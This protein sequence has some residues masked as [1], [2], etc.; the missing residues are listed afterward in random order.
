MVFLGLSG[1]HHTSHHTPVEC[2]SCWTYWCSVVK[3]VSHDVLVNTDHDSWWGCSYS[4][5]IGQVGHDRIEIVRIHLNK[6]SQI[7]ARKGGV[8]MSSS[9]PQECRICPRS[10]HKSKSRVGSLLFW[11]SSALSEVNFRSG[12]T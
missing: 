3:L 2:D 11:K 7:K 5:D 12:F 9:A 1:V 6:G 10:N 8:D 4:R